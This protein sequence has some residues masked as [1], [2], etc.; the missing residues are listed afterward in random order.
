MNDFRLNRPD[1]ILAEVGAGGCWGGGIRHHLGRSGD[2]EVGQ[3]SGVGVLAEM[4]K[5]DSC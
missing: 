1:W 5:L 3:V 2:E 4:T